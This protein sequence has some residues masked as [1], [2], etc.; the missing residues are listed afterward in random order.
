MSKHDFIPNAKQAKQLAFLRKKGNPE[1]M[2]RLADVLENEFQKADH[3]FRKCEADEES[4][5][6]AAI[7]LDSYNAELMHIKCQIQAAIAALPENCESTAAH[8][9]EAISYGTRKLDGTPDASASSD[10]DEG[11]DGACAGG[12]VDQEEDL[13]PM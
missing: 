5:E 13:C 9:L 2:A 3:Y 10:L 1:W 12:A 7:V 8:L 4:F 11:V 6:R